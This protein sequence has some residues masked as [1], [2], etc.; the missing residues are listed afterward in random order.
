MRA[1]ARDDVGRRRDRGVQ[2]SR[3]RR[4]CVWRACTRAVRAGRTAAAT[5]ARI[6]RGHSA[7]TAGRR[8]KAEVANSAPAGQD[9][10]AS[11]NSARMEEERGAG[12]HLDADDISW[13]F[14]DRGL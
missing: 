8:R 9:T 7:V 14:V 10:G 2:T 4:G 13:G 12:V 11:H 1:E 5:R 3:A 6:V